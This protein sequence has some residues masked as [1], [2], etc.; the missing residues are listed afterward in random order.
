MILHY[1]CTNETVPVN[2][3]KCSKHNV[4]IE[5]W[6][7]GY[8][9]KVL[10]HCPCAAVTKLSSSRAERSKIE[11]SIECSLIVQHPASLT[12]LKL[13]MRSNRG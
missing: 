6:D 7:F 9:S 11:I 4:S 2:V 12:P 1:I 10:R 5:Q 8:S 3:Y 13:T